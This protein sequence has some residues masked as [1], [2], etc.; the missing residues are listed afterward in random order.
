MWLVVRGEWPSKH[1][2]HIN[3]NPLDNRIE[4]LR[5]G[6]LPL[7]AEGAAQAG[8]SPADL[9]ITTQIIAAA[10]TD[11]T[12]ARRDAA[13]QVGFYATPKGYDAPF[14]GGADAAER[15]AAREAVARNDVDGVTAAGQAMA[16][17]RA[18]Y[19][20]PEEIVEQLR[21]YADVVDWAL[22]YPPNYGVDPERVHAN[23]RLL[24]EIAAAV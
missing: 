3:G 13:A 22:L 12:A 19:G 14:P 9:R 21:R 7:L 15:Q 23:E 18:V 1:I 2:D 8:R 10:D 24:I 5:D 16:Q 4:N 6:A 17:D 11:R 20:T